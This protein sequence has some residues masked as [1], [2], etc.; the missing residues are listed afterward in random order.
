MLV[1]A[2][3]GEARTGKTTLI[4]KLRKLLEAKGLTVA[5]WRDKAKFSPVGVN[6]DLYYLILALELQARL[7]RYSAGDVDVL[8]VDRYLASMYAYTNEPLTRDLIKKA[9]SRLSSPD[10]WIWVMAD[11]PTLRSMHFRE[12]FDLFEQDTFK[13]RLQPLP[14]DK[15]IADV[16]SYIE[17][18]LRHTLVAA[19]LEES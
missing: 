9:I 3:D 10:L 17:R 16:A 4:E 13:F 6:A 8:L 2:V 7:R 12:F 19:E 15:V 5:E 14:S 18:K 11:E 1:V